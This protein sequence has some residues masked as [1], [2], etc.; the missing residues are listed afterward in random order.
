M[1]PAQ[2][3][4]IGWRDLGL[5][6]LVC[7]VWAFNFVAGA[8][9]MQ[10]FSPLTFMLGRFAIVLLLTWPFLRRPPAGQW[11]RLLAVALLIGGLHF[12]TMFWALQRSADVTSIVIIQHAYIP[13][14][15]L[16]AL[17]LLREHAGWRTLLAT[18]VAFGGLLLI[19]FDPLVLGQLDALALGLFSA[20]C[21]ALGAVLMRDLKGMGVFSFLAWTAVISIPVLAASS[22]LLESGQWSSITQAEGVHW[23]SLVYSALGAS[24]VGHGLF[25][26]LVQR[27]R[28]PVLMPYLLMTPVYGIAFG[29]LLWGDRPGIRLLAGGAIVLCA[30]LAITLRNRS[31]ALAGS[32]ATPVE[33]S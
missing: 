27:T 21:Q 7:L 14:A 30:V 22:W 11:P 6:Q 13:M 24:L 2:P 20:F 5:S 19:G 12:T 15:V 10:A 32:V 28:M 16:L 9:A 4:A 23:A 25:Y 8:K 18:G 3:A 29:V 26:V 33:G 31:K 17:P 1:G